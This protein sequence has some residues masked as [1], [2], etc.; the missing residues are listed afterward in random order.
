MQQFLKS[1]VAIATFAAISSSA[2]AFNAGSV[3]VDGTAVTPVL[4]NGAIAIGSTD[5]QSVVITQGT[6]SY[7]IA[8]GYVDSSL[9]KPTAQAETATILGSDISVSSVRALQASVLGG[10]IVVGDENTKTV[11][12]DGSYMGIFAL[13]GGSVKINAENLV[14]NSGTFGIHS[15]NNTES[16]TAPDGTSE[17][18]I[19]AA[20]TTITSD[21][22]GISAFS[23]GYVEVN[24]N[25]TVNAKNAIDT[26]GFATIV[27]NKAGTGTVV[28][29]GDIVFETPGSSQNSGNYIGSTVKLNLSGAG[30]SWT[31]NAYKDYP[32]SNEGTAKYN[33]TSGL[34]VSISDG[35]QWTPTA[36]TNSDDGTQIIKYQSINNLEL[37]DGVI[38]ITSDLVGSDAA[39]VTVDNLSGTG[40]TINLE[41]TK[42]DDGFSAAKFVATSVD[43]TESTPA[44]AVNFTGITADDLTNAAEDLATLQSNITAEGTSQ[45]LSVAE[46]DVNGAV[47]A[48]VDAD[49]GTISTPTTATNTKLETLS[50]VTSLATIQW[51]HEMNDL[52]KRMGELRDQPGTL[53]SWARIYGAEQKYGRQNVRQKSTSIQVGSDYAIGDWK[54]GGAFSYTDGSTTYAQGSGDTETF[55]LAAYGS[56]ISDNG[57]FLDLIAKYSRIESKFD[58]A[59]MSG[60]TKNN[61]YSVSAE[62]GWHWD[63]NEIAFVEPQAELTYGRIIGDDVTASNGVRIEQDDFS[64]LIGRIGLRGG[65]KFPEKRGNIYARVSAVYDF[66]GESEAMYSKGTNTSRITD[67]IGGAWVEYGIGANF[68]LT[69]RTYTYVDL[70]RTSGGDVDELWRFNIGLRHTWY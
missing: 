44:L 66:D 42:T 2:F 14:V 63:V 27:I 55:G 10:N 25:L 47:T 3:T 12:L 5:A 34:Y 49:T 53:G 23:N 68:N 39:A 41:T 46:G 38:N 28:L 37:N 69:D 15:Q 48:T 19:N 54:V 40:G 36:V 52:T 21:Q 43:T 24:G 26:R 33:E 17:I 45:T 11:T 57:F 20:N 30:S 65:L 61:A 13:K 9:E 35:A 32:K 8:V 16:T 51:R 29:N 1:A 50:S 22:I 56:W 58:I 62:A 59:N 7:G 67:D 31:G 18:I 64:S 70:E 4:E 6:S 60:K